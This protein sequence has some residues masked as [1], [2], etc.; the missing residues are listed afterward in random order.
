MHITHL[1]IHKTYMN[2]L[3]KNHKMN[4]HVPTIQLKNATYKWIWRLPVS[5]FLSGSP[6]A[7]SVLVNYSHAFLYSFNIYV[8]LPKLNIM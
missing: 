7:S 1:K 6:K 4:N 3:K 2:S 8:P 5:P